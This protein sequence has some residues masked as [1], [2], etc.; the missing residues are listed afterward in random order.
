MR[1]HKQIDRDRLKIKSFFYCTAQ[2]VRKNMFRVRRILV[3]HADAL[4]QHCRLAVQGKSV[5][6]DASDGLGLPC[7]TKKVIGEALAK[8]TKLTT[9]NC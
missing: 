3:I 5:R 7:P 9:S 1:S 6:G 4:Q 8:K 2:A